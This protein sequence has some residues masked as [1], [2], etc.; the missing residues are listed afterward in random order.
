MGYYFASTKHKPTM[1]FKRVIDV[2]IPAIGLAWQENVF[3]IVPMLNVHWQ[4]NR[5]YHWNY[6][7]VELL[8]RLQPDNDVTILHPIK[9]GAGMKPGNGMMVEAI[10]TFNLVFVALSVTNPRGKIAIMPSFPI[11]FCIGTG[12]MA[13]VGIVPALSACLQAL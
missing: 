12:I 9:P 13:A 8:F 6:G 3:A 2:I 10:L 7:C 11:A 1:E 4:C 5:A